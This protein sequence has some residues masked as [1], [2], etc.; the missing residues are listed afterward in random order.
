MCT[1]REDHVGAA[2]D[3][4]DLLE[5]PLLTRN[6]IMPSEQDSYA[7]AIRGLWHGSDACPFHKGNEQTKNAHGELTVARYWQ[8]LHTDIGADQK[9]QPAVSEQ[10]LQSPGGSVA[11]IQ[12]MANKLPN[13]PEMGTKL[14][15]KQPHPL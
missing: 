7:E 14:T 12:G 8:Y 9:A 10:S 15:E 3:N 11:S 13:E 2:R 6:V 1:K 4:R 5:S